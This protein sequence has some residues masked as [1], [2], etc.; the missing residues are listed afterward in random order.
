[1]QFQQN[2]F[3][4]K[5]Y[6]IN[7]LQIFFL[8]LHVFLLFG[9]FFNRFEFFWLFLFHILL[10]MKNSVWNRIFIFGL[11]MLILRLLL[12][13]KNCFWCRFC[14]LS[15]FI[16]PMQ[17]NNFNGRIKY[18]FFSNLLFIFFRGIFFLL[19]FPLTFTWQHFI[20]FIYL[21]FYIIFYF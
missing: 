20:I 13:F 17:L 5:I 10:L 6:F 2:H 21:P 19:N 7:F 1:M 4:S 9:T 15:F 14:V 11:I 12:N 3:W 16:S 18:I 8:L